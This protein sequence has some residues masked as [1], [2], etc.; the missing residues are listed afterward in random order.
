MAAMGALAGSIA[1]RRYRV[2]GAPPAD[3]KE[4]FDKS[5]RAHAL[6][7]V[8]PSRNED[9]SI[10]WCSLHDENDL[11]LNFGKFYFDERIILSLRVDVL[12][13]PAAQVK[14]LLQQRKN[15]LEAQRHAPLSAG[16]LR[17]LKAILIAEL[18]QKTPPKTKTV[19]M[20]W[21]LDSQRLYFFSHS[22]GLNETFVGLFAQT[23]NLPIDLEGPGF[24]ASQLTED[25]S[26][27]AATFKAARP[28]PELLQGFI[29]LRPGPRVLDEIEMLQTSLSAAAP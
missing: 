12:K 6:V 4:S 10:G 11:D 3:F 17:D 23:F 7:P 8:D 13:P 19:D 29:G 2:L 27:L 24:W 25:E 26:A 16:A 1:V 28:T 14:R 22:K 15:E 18:R 20:V 5:V 21:E 9:R